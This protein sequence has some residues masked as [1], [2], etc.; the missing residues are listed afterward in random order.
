MRFAFLWISS[1]S[2]ALGCGSATS[3]TAPPPSDPSAEANIPV[4]YPAIPI[5]VAAPVQVNAKGPPVDPGYTVFTPS[6]D[7][8]VIY[9]SSS[10]GNDANDGM[11][12]ERPVRSVQQG[13]SLLRNGHP[14]WLLFKRGDVW[15]EGLGRIEMSGRSPSDRM[16]YGAYGEGPRPRFEFKGNFLSTDGGGDAL[17]VDN[18][19][20]TSLDAFGADYDPERGTPTGAQPSCVGWC[21][22]GRDVLFEDMRFQ[23]CGVVIMECDKIAIERVRFYRSLFLDAYSANEGHSSGIYLHHPGEVSIEEC[24]FDRCGWNP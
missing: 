9:V 17:S 3:S 24:V 15:K 23:Y 1:V 21:R 19:V 14:D 18:V 11:S 12:E 6:A 4:A 22:G 7:T 5:T 16:V 2:A 8:K 20:F 10:Q 13:K